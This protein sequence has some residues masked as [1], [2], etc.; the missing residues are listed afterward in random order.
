MKKRQKKMAN[1]TL[2]ELLVVIAIIAILVS[3]L[4]PALNKARAAANRAAC[5]NNLKQ[6]GT[7][8]Q[9]YFADFEDYIPS[10]HNGEIRWTQLFFREY[11][12]VDKTFLCPSEPK[13]TFEASGNSGSCPYGYTRYLANYTWGGA[14]PV[15]HVKVTALKKPSTFI[16]IADVEVAI[17]SYQLEKVLLL[18]SS[19]LGAISNR[20]D[21]YANVLSPVGN[22]A[23]EKS[24][25]LPTAEIIRW[26][27]PFQQ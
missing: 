4:L 14:L 10:Y 22:V 9:L 1:F 8:V 25:T 3:M 23:A 2:I 13:R 17:N 7:T 6:F 11:G 24:T 15:K 5:I 21:H 20:H 18:S 19:G 16:L 12:I 26:K 27:S